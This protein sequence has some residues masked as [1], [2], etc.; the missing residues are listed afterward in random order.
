MRVTSIL[1]AVCAAAAFAQSATSSPQPDKRYE[2][3]NRHGDMAMGFSHLKTTHH[4]RLLAGGGAIEVLANQSGDRET[5]DHVRMH[6]QHTAQAFAEGDF[7][8]PTLTHSRTPPGVPAM[9]RLKSQISYRYE[10]TQNGARI[11]ITT[12]NPEA[13][14]AVHA[15]LR[16]QI[17][18][19]QSG[20]PK[21]V[22]AQ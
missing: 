9:R 17:D 19:H 10:E 7:R 1:V 6:L 21:A 12:A 5:L 16:F 14:K 4:F 13:L 15:F 8:D 3:V 11:L 20:D 2:D 18:D 22:K